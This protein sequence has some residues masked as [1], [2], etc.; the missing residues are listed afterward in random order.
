MDSE[1]TQ[2]LPNQSPEPLARSVPLSRFTSQVGGGSAFYVDMATFIMRIISTIISLV[3]MLGFSVCEATAQTSTNTPVR[4]TPAMF[5]DYEYTL[6]SDKDYLYYLFLE[7][8]R[9]EETFGNKVK[10]GGIV[11]L[12]E[13]WKIEHG[14]TLVF[15]GVPDIPRPDGTGAFQNPVRHTLQ[16]KSFGEKIVVTMDGD[17]YKRSKFKLPN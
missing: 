14:N 7:G 6:I 5:T 3:L 1:F 12:G 9:V 17:K 11:A 13:G 2:M 8:G 16:F 15:T 4:L 10:N